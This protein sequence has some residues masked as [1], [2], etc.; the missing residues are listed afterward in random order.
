MLEIPDNL[1]TKAFRDTWDLWVQHRKE[2][3]KKITPTAQKLQL[4]KLSAWGE[5]KA[6]VAI[7]TSIESGWQGLFEPKEVKSITPLAHLR[8]VPPVQEQ[9]EEFT[10]E[11]KAA[12][13]ARLRQMCK[14]GG[15]L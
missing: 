4:R 7:E 6:I 11:Q 12:N 8:I 14:S 9:A 1:D 15:L 10:R 2:L 3:K 13:M 5:A